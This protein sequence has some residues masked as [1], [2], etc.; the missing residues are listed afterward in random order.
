MSNI[1]KLEHGNSVQLFPLMEEMMRP[2]TISKME[3]P[4]LNLFNERM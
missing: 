1:H 3:K 4:R 2:G